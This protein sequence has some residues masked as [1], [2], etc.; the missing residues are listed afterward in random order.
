MKKECLA[1]EGIEGKPGVIARCRMFI[2]NWKTFSGWYFCETKPEIFALA[3][4]S[5]G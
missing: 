1:Y 4:P 3:M 5:L 2:K